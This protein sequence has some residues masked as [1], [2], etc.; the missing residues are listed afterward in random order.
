MKKIL[1]VLAMLAVIL[2]VVLLASYVGHAQ[3]KTTTN[4]LT[5]QG[6][7]FTPAQVA[8]LPIGSSWYNTTGDTLHMKTPGGLFLWDVHRSPGVGESW[9]WDGHAFV[10]TTITG[11]N[12]V[13]G[14]SILVFKY[15]DGTGQK[16]NVDTV[17]V[18]IAQL[19]MI[20]SAG[21]AITLSTVQAIDTTA[22]PKWRGAQ[23]SYLDPYGPLYLNASRQTVSLS[24]VASGSSIISNGT[25]SAPI[26]GKIGL[27]THVSGTLPIANGGLNS[28]D[29]PA[30]GQL[31]YGSGTAWRASGPLA[32]D[33]F[34]KS[35][36]PP[37]A[38]DLFGAANTF[39]QDQYIAR[40]FAYARW[41]FQ[42]GQSG[43]EAS[44]GL[45]TAG[46]LAVGPTL[47]LDEYTGTIPLYHVGR[48]GNALDFQSNTGARRMFA[49]FTG[50][51]TLGVGDSVQL[52]S[53]QLD[54]NWV[55]TANMIDGGGGSG[56]I[57]VRLSTGKC[58]FSTTE[59]QSVSG[60]RFTYVIVPKP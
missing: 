21:N 13:I 44:V 11:G 56:D 53:A 30:F 2:G 52:S 40:D 60:V 46:G 15:T 14:D 58:T 25:S 29:P 32:Y 33:Q 6:F 12:G 24:P 20:A 8:A 37:T 23:F 36:N 7:N 26:W 16:L 3:T 28:V 54:T 59:I 34:L 38:F 41:H 42:E 9:Q 22:V 47:G 43:A 49:G 31:L 27:T 5:L 19:L 1:F 17:K 10:L 51:L 4:R 45:S 55:A 39:T 35:T 48:N 57:K 50:T 18:D